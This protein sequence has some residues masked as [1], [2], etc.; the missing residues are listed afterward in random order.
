MGSDS[1]IDIG[2]RTFMSINHSQNPENSTLP[3]D[4][5]DDDFEIITSE[6]VDS[7]V[8]ALEGLIAKTQSE[9]IRCILEE[10]A[11][12]IF[13]LVYSEDEAACEDQEE[14]A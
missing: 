10:A 2:G 4:S 9:N 12:T 7:I 5:G 13:S 8:E 1:L 3:L 14:A 11:D 6:E